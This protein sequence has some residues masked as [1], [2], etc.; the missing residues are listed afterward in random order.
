MDTVYQIIDCVRI[1]RLK[2]P[3]LPPTKYFKEINIYCIC[4]II[5]F[6]L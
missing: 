1:P 2:D 3:K 5:Y 4:Y 6:K